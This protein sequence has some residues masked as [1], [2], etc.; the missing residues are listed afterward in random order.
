MNAMIVVHVVIDKDNPMPVQGMIKTQIQ[1][2]GMVLDM[3]PILFSCPDMSSVQALVNREL[4]E[5]DTLSKAKT[6]KE[7][8]KLLEPK[9]HTWVM[10]GTG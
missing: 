2:N 7:L 4:S 5:W 3:R 8:D 9:T 1:H 10:K 6:K